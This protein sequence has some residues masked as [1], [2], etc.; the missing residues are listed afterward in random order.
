M[1]KPLCR[2]KN[3]G[4]NSIYSQKL[5]TVYYD[6]K[7]NHFFPSTVCI[8][9]DGLFLKVCNEKLRLL[10][11]C[12]AISSPTNVDYTGCAYGLEYINLLLNVTL[13]KNPGKTGQFEIVY[14]ILS[15]ILLVNWMIPCIFLGFLNTHR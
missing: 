15:K 5:C 1:Y 12:F 10:I 14:R 3:Y 7:W 9:Y 11:F 13:L 4:L 6:N 8:Y 2:V